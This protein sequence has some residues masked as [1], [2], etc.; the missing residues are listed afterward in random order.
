MMGWDRG[1]RA[2]LCAGVMALAG[3]QTGGGLT[4][5]ALAPAKPVSVLDGIKVAGP[6]GYCPD[7]ASVQE[8]DDS[9]VAFLGRCSADSSQRPAVLTLTF[10]R[11]GS[12]GV[13]TAGGAEL[14]RFFTSTTGR[15]ALSRRGRAGDVKLSSARTLGDIYLMRIEDRGQGDYWRG[16]ITLRGRLVSVSATGPDLPAEEGLDLVKDTMAALRRSNRAK[17]HAE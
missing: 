11:S 17:A 9:A 2:L 8:R 15:K 5:S 7:P 14:A 3:C 1:A 10:G 16:M 13:M 6:K 12:A 4:L